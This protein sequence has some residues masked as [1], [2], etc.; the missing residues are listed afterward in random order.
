MG[1]ERQCSRVRGKPVIGWHS[2]ERLEKSET[3]AVGLESDCSGQTR[4]SLQSPGMGPACELEQQSEAGAAG[5]M[6]E[7]TE[8]AQNEKVASWPGPGRQSSLPASGHRTSGQ[9]GDP[10][11]PQPP[12]PGARG[13][14]RGWCQSLRAAGGTQPPRTTEALPGFPSTSEGDGRA[15][16]S[17]ANGT[18]LVR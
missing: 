15:R 2:T 10:R 11:T 13:L 18:W 7:G 17:P 8:A 6:R 16:Y 3:S 4:R 9:T 14:Q 12:R 5:S 1:K